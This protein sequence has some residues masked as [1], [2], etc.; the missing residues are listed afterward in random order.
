M[1]D[2]ISVGELL[3]LLQDYYGQLRENNWALHTDF[4]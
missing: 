4:K 2:A 3:L 1:S